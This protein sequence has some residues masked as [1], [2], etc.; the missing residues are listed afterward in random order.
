[1]KKL[2][3]VASMLM[4]TVATFAQKGVD[5]GSKYGH[6]ADSVRCI[7]NLV[8]YSDAVKIKDFKGAYEPWLVVFNECPLAKK[9]TLYIDGV[10]IAKALYKSTKDEQYYDLLLKVYDQ[11]MKYY[12]ND[13]NYPTSY[14]KG[15]KALDILSYKEDDAANKT[16]IELFEDAFK[17]DA[18][19]IQPAFVQKYILST[20][21]L[22]K[23]GVYTAENVVNNYITAGDVIAS[24]QN[25][26]K[27]FK[28]D[29]DKAEFDEL[30]LTTKDQVDQIFA[31]SGAA[32]VETLNNVF[33]PQLEANKTNVEWLK[34]V[35]KFLSKSKGGDESELFFATSENLHKI[36]PTAS[37]AR[38]LARMSMKKNNMEDAVS[39]YKQAIELEEDN[40]D[41]AKYYYELAAVQFSQ[42]SFAAAKSAALSAAGLREGWGDPYI[43]LGKIY[44]AGAPTIG[45][46]EW[47]KKAGYWA[48]VDKFAKAKAIDE[49]V[50][51]EATQ[52][53]GQY[54]Q[55]FPNKEDLFMHG[56]NVGESYTVGGFIGETT[57]V[58][59]K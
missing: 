11:R 43:L 20:V 8:Q 51:A 16:S 59:A 7:M 42:H 14:L 10:K 48:A 41:K 35:N 13:K 56:V 49:T 39:Y 55:Y 57:R 34:K 21:N 9:T 17:G 26:G 23:S 40:A 1:M 28:T 46:E 37:S 58:R 4:G 38:G 53:I 22:Y 25:S 50:A 44:A 52:L 18:K 45:S 29:K 24:I 36:E 27:K 6:G 31:Q 54:S 32:D 33:G 30:V 12:G 47:E 5:D 19:T 3:L 15:M 2:V